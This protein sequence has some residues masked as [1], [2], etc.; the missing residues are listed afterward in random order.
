MIRTLLIDDVALARNKLR[1][2][3]GAH[4]SRWHPG[5]PARTCHRGR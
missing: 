3:L 1:H 5:S 4:P 2:L